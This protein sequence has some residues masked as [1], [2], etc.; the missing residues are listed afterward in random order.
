MK[1]TMHNLTNRGVCDIISSKYLIH[2][3]KKDR[4]DNMTIRADGRFQA[5]IDYGYDEF[6][7]RKRKTIYG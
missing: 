6:G 5:Q 7:K 3:Y 2:T 1:N 4:S